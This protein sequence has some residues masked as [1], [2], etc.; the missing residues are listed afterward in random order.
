MER[1]GI[2]LYFV[3][4]QNIIFIRVKLSPHG[5]LGQNSMLFEDPIYIPNDFIY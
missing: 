1:I 4:E 5:K 2:F 3:C